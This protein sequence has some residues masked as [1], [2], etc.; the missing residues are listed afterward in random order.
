MAT[1]EKNT[2]IFFKKRCERCKGTGLERKKKKEMCFLCIKNVICFKCENKSDKGLYRE[3][4]D[5]LGIG[6]HFY[7]KNNKKIMRS[8]FL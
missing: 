1:Y 6:E 7:D 8:N 3:C 2:T 4:S 5:C